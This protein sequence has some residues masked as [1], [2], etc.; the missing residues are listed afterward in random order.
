MSHSSLSA[1]LASLHSKNGVSSRQHSDAVGRGIHHSSNAGHTILNNSVKHKPSV[2]YP[3]SKAAAIA[4]VPFTTLRENAV[5][6]LQ[7]LSQHSSPLFDANGQHLPWKKLFGPKSIKYERGINS[8]DTNAK[9]DGLLKDALHLLSTAWGD[10]INTMSASSSSFIQLG[11]NKPSSVLHALEYLV[12]KYYVHV[13]NAETL[14]VSF[15]P[16][17]ETFLFD[18][19]LQ[20]VDLSQYPHWS[21]LRPFSAARGLSGVPRTVIAKWA[22]STKDNGGGIVIVQRICEVAKRAAKIHSQERK[23]GL[24]RE[25]EVRR[26]I[27]ICISFAAATMAETFHIQRSATGSIDESL[28]RTIIPVVFSALEPLNGKHKSG[29][30][31][32]NWS[33]GALCPE[34]RSFGRIM[35]SL[36]VDNCE[37]SEELNF[38]LANA[39]VR[40]CVESIQLARFDELELDGKGVDVT[41]K[42]ADYDLD[43]MSSSSKQSILEIASDAILTIMTISQSLS[44]T[45]KGKEENNVRSSLSVVTSNRKLHSNQCIGYNVSMRIFRIIMKIPFLASAIGHV[46]NEKDIDV[47]SLLATIF[48]M[49]IS[50]M[51]SKQ[52][53]YQKHSNLALDLVSTIMCKFMFV[54]TLKKLILT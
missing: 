23:L 3:D 19:I 14:L 25:E 13:H 20:L 21:F 22:A 49:S 9:F 34:W 52:K 31:K 26:G 7:F 32:M 39:I 24:N 12:Q 35:I 30:S 18:R 33:V 40:G 47:R 29:K 17:H 16:H 28:L 44:H 2:L 11:A 48:A 38:T 1:Q 42:I 51:G 45:L 46:S 8:K 41:S 5:A 50:D 10:S 6:S 37:L 54:I 36:L 4:D 15:L 27:S 43:D 53:E